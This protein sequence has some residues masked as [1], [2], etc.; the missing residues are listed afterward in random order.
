MK[1]YRGSKRT[2]SSQ[3]FFHS[4][5]IE[6]HIS[7]NIRGHKS[8]YMYIV[9]RRQSVFSTAFFAIIVFRIWVAGEIVLNIY[10]WVKDKINSFW[11]LVKTSLKSGRW[12]SFFRH[13]KRSAFPLRRKIAY[14][15]G[16]PSL[17]V[18]DSWCRWPSD[19]SGLRAK[20]DSGWCPLWFLV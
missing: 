18:P 7:K 1:I 17:F 3:I 19:F 10:I 5:W 6:K 16:F 14:F 20:T 8:C 2:L 12:S 13:L 11:Y 4:K 9:W 15:G